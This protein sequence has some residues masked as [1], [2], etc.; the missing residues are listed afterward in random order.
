MGPRARLRRTEYVGTTF[1][2]NLKRAFRWGRRQ[3]DVPACAV[4]CLNLFQARSPI[5]RQPLRPDLEAFVFRYL[6]ARPEGFCTSLV[7]R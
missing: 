1:W 6:A 5:L 2:P 7:K 4:G 3:A